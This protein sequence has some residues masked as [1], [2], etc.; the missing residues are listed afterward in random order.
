GIPEVYFTRSAE[1]EAAPASK[2]RVEQLRTGQRAAVGGHLR[3]PLLRI[4]PEASHGVRLTVA[5]VPQARGAREPEGSLAE[6]PE[7]VEL[8][9]D[10]RS[11]AVGPG[12][13][14]GKGLR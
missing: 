8:R 9:A 12:R 7:R 6:R 14:V 5:E 2:L 13:R 3:P 11:R 10:R 1:L 4:L